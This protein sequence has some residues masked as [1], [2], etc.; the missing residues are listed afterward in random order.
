[1]SRRMRYDACQSAG[2]A[3]SAR[4]YSGQRAKTRRSTSVCTLSRP[5]RCTRTVAV[6]ELHPHTPERFRS[7]NVTALG[8]TAS[9][10]SRTSARNGAL[11]RNALTAQ[12]VRHRL[13]S[14]PAHQRVVA[15][16]LVCGV[17]VARA[18]THNL[19]ARSPPPRLSVRPRRPWFRSRSAPPPTFSASPHSRC[20]TPTCR[21]RPHTRTSISSLPITAIAPASTLHFFAHLRDSVRRAKPHCFFLVRRHV[22]DGGRRQALRVCVCVCVCVWAGPRA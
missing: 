1:M 11:F 9:C 17:A 19:R 22:D 3:Q 12:L 16:A 13:L 8:V 20:R 5:P 2:D 4:E 14:P 6:K 10:P 21:A 18:E 7:R 15:I